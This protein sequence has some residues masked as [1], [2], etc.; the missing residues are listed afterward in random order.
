VK[1]QWKGQPFEEDTWE[2]EWEMQRSYPHLLET[3]R[4]ILDPFEDEYLFKRGRM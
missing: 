4:M 2:I 3:P 1:V